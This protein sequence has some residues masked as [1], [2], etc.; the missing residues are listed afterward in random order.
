MT[1]E[2]LRVL[3][4]KATPGPWCSNESRVYFPN[5]KGGFDLRCA[6]RADA[7]A[8]YI[9]AA[10]PDVVVGLLD[11]IAELEKDAKRY[12][13]IRVGD[14]DNAVMTWVHGLDD[15]TPWESPEDA[16]AAIDAAM[17]EQG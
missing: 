5:L 9:A 13:F 17:G 11:R 15:W 8:A 6:P 10:S 2:E 3:A 12:R 16:D 7:N 14:P 4:E 1:N